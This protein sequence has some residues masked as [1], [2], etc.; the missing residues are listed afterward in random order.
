MTNG[1]RERESVFPPFLVAVPHNG[2][3]RH[4]NLFSEEDGRPSASEHEIFSQDFM[5]LSLIIV[6][7]HCGS[8]PG[9]DP[10]LSLSYYV[11]LRCLVFFITWSFTALLLRSSSAAAAHV[12]VV[13][14]MKAGAPRTV[15]TVS[16][17]PTKKDIGI[18]LRVAGASIPPQRPSAAAAVEGTR[19]LA[20]SSSH[21]TVTPPCT[22]AGSQAPAAATIVHAPVSGSYSLSIDKMMQRPRDALLASTL[23]R[24]RMLTAPPPLPSSTMTGKASVRDPKGSSAAEGPTLA[25]SADGLF[26]SVPAPGGKKVKKSKEAPALRDVAM[27]GCLHA[28]LRDAV[29]ARILESCTNE[30]AWLRAAELVFTAASRGDAAAAVA[31]SSAATV[32][33]ATASCFPPP[34]TPLLIVPVRGNLPVVR[35]FR[36]PSVMYVGI[37]TVCSQL[38]VD[39]ADGCPLEY[40]WCLLPRGVKEG[41]PEGTAAPEGGETVRDGKRTTPP[42]TAKLVSTTTTTD[43]DVIVLCRSST[44]TPTNDTVGHRIRIRVRPVVVAVGAQ[45][46]AHTDA[47][48]AMKGDL[49]E[50]DLAA[51][52]AANAAAAVS[53][54]PIA[55]SLVQWAECDTTAAVM[56]QTEAFFSH[57]PRGGHIRPRRRPTDGSPSSAS[58]SPSPPPLTANSVVVGGAPSVDASNLC[59]PLVVGGPSSDTDAST[60]VVRVVTYNILHDGFATSKYAR[61]KLYP[62]CRGELLDLNYRKS[63]VVQ[64]LL[65]YD[66]DILCLQEV[67]RELYETYL[68][69]V[70]DGAGWESRITLKGSAKAEG[71]VTAFRKSMFVLERYDAYPL[72]MA[73]L[74]SVLPTVAAAIKAQSDHFEEAMANVPSMGTVATLRC[75]RNPLS[76]ASGSYGGVAAAA[77]GDSAIDV[78]R[79]VV[80]NTHLYYHGG[81]CHIRAVQSATLAQLVHQRRIEIETDESQTTSPGELRGIGGASVRRRRVAC[82][83]AGDYNSTRCAASYALATRGTVDPDHQSW[84]KSTLFWWGLGRE[85][86]AGGG[87]GASGKKGTAPAAALVA[88][89][90][91]IE[92]DDGVIAAAVA[93]P[94]DE[95]IVAQLTASVDVAASTAAMPRY[96]RFSLPPSQ[97]PFR[98]DIVLG[99]TFTDTHLGLADLK[100]TNYCVGFKEVIDHIFI[101]PCAPATAGPRDVAAARP[102]EEK[103]TVSD[104]P[105]RSRTDDN[106]AEAAAVTMSVDWVLPPP[107]EETCSMDTALPNK[108]FPSDHI[109]LVADVRITL[110][111]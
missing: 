77:D 56:P 28:E 84:R 14:R 64:E 1:P 30:D 8:S 87:G 60:M 13:H 45:P 98:C 111:P 55:E 99:G 26:A 109:A 75:V 32:E 89:E 85:G 11:S 35:S 22:M 104:L 62:F 73:T 43:A 16:F 15:V 103:G 95:S 4:Y 3:R 106:V 82:I 5:L 24:I 18:H 41:E 74:A 110:A 29:G 49:A 66:G 69:D 94:T 42:A 36:P 72:N 100:F 93:V 58:G 108:W 96:G 65:A 97:T 80:S 50:A 92:E 46:P 25:S 2:F 57:V 105:A 90:E 76:A 38:V 59:L 51:A 107:R 83:A 88:D 63:R 10:S 102:D 61:T 70:L 12:A 101:S 27:A 6:Y 20:T 9:L 48:A 7:L 34:F 21:A 31:E 33:G 40:E 44:F 86:P 37:P 39:F 81:A 67:G 19:P 71:C 68:R 78:L 91:G 79:V 52:A 17:D 23:D 54:D 47:I 53:I